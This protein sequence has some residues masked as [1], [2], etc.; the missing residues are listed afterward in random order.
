[1]TAETLTTPAGARPVADSVEALREEM[2]AQWVGLLERSSLSALVQSGEIDRRLYAL[3]LIETFHYTRE[4]P[5]HQALVGARSDADPIYLK[6]C[7]K[8][9]ADEVGHEMMALHDLRSI[10]Y[11]VTAD[12]LPAPLD[13]TEVLTAYLYRI[14]QVG[15]P[16]ARVGYSFWAESSYEH[17]GPLLAAAQGKLGLEDKNMTFLV[18]HAKIDADHAEEVD[19][20][21]RRFATTTD[22]WDAVGRVM[23]TSLRLTVEMLDAVADEYRAVADGRSRR[24]A[25]IEI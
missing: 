15:N 5:R 17:I 22:D 18:A 7:L 9:A 25:A 20:V 1:M 13:A 24:T 21:L 11:D 23:R 12:D 8:H 6:F 4:N 3:Y 10:G 16:L 2:A 14:S 19:A